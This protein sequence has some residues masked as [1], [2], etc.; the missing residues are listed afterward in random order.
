MCSG[1]MILRRKDKEEKCLHTLEP[2]LGPIRQEI[3][4]N[5]KGGSDRLHLGS[6]SWSEGLLTPREGCGQG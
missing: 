1:S 5:R 6:F 2:G 3:P 4:G